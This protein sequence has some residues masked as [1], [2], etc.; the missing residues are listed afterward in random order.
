MA[1]LTN[2]KNRGK[3]DKMNNNKENEMNVSS[4]TTGF[5]NKPTSSLAHEV[6]AWMQAHP[7]ACKNTNSTKLANY[8]TG[9]VKG[10]PVS[11]AQV[12]AKLVRQNLLE[13][14]GTK[15]NSTFYINYA[16]SKIPY[17]ILDKAPEEEKERLRRRIEQA[18]STGGEIDETGCVVTKSVKIEEEPE[19]KPE[20]EPEE[21]LEEENEEDTTAV[22]KLDEPE[23]EREEELT[24][25]EPIASSEEPTKIPV[26]ATITSTK[27]GLNLSLNININL[28]LQH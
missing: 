4:V 23:E 28:T 20:E 2:I 17:D 3:I 12:I 25:L 19:E 18:V 15:Q 24:T 14:I 7:N 13:R 11:R 21:E 5:Y 10:K 22:I 6:L 8:M 1:V 27:D 9:Q 16:H 26:N